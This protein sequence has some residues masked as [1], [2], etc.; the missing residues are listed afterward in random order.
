MKGDKANHACVESGQL[1]GRPEGKTPEGK[2][3]REGGRQRRGGG[4]G[5]GAAGAKADKAGSK[6]PGVSR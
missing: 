2:E 1:A 6:Q 3:G 4:P 5:A